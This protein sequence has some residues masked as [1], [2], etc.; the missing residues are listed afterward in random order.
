MSLYMKELDE[1]GKEAVSAV[2]FSMSMDTV[3]LYS[4]SYIINITC[5][6]EKAEKKFAQ[7]RKCTKVYYSCFCEGCPIEKLAV[8]SLN[9]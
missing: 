6:D 9:N 4:S 8:R 7:F 2:P 1:E 3:Y 5:L